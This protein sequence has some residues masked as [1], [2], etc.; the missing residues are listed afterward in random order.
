MKSSQTEFFKLDEQ[1]KGSNHGSFMSFDVEG[2]LSSR[3]EGEE[4][5]EEELNSENFTANSSCDRYQ[6]KNI[7][8][9]QVD[10]K[11]EDAIE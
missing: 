6:I 4:E 7:E 1:T 9:V 5:G 3:Q 8:M 10:N 2:S 11:E